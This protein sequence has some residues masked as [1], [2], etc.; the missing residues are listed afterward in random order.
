MNRLTVPVPIDDLDSVIEGQLVDLVPVLVEYGRDGHGPRTLA[1]HAA[2][3]ANQQQKQ[4]E[5]H[6][7]H[8][9]KHIQRLIYR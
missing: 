5:G 8:I 6:P 3:Y 7:V 9:Y 1:N 2:R 4:H